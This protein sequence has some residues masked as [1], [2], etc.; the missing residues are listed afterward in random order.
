MREFKA[1]NS[2]ISAPT[3]QAAAFSSSM[4]LI[5]VPALW[6]KNLSFALIMGTM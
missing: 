3:V 5:T 1:L 6:D 4:S 2:R